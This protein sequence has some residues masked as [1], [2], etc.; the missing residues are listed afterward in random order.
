M[1]IE[2]E[3]IFILQALNDAIDM[4]ENGEKDYFS[5]QLLLLFLE[6]VAAFRKSCTCFLEKQ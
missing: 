2:Q 1:N 5:K 3:F 6:A 4:I